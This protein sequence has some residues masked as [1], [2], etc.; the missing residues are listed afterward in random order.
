MHR[1]AVLT[2][3]PGVTNLGTSTKCPIQI[4]YKPGRLLSFQGHP[5]FDEPIND[6]I[7]KVEYE[8]GNAFDDEAFQ[9]AIKRVDRPHDGVLLS[10]SIMAFFLGSGKWKHGEE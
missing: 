9:D 2:V 4:L 3:P 6:E 1:D 8:H 7:L 10:S 5:E